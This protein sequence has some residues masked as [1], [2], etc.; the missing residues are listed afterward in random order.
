MSSE[1][2]PTTLV[3]HLQTATQ[4]YPHHVAIR[5][6][7]NGEW[8]E[9][10][11]ADL[12]A[13]TTATTRGLIANGLQPGDRVCV[14]SQTRPEWTIVD[15]AILRAG[16]VVVPVYPTSSP[17]EIRWIVADSGA[18]WIVC[19]NAEMMA[20][21]DAVAGE[22]PDLEHRYLI[23]DDPRAP[24]APTLEGLRTTGT[25]TSDDQLA[26][27][28]A[29][30]EPGSVSTVMYTSGTTG[31]PKGCLLTHQNLTSTI[32]AVAAAD[33]I[34]ASDTVY[35]F[36]PL[37]H[38]FAR[39]VQMTAVQTGATVAYFGGDISNVI[40]ELSEVRPTF[41]PSVPRIFEKIHA[42]ATAGAADAS[43]PKRAVFDWSLTVGR[44]RA[45]A[46]QAGRPITGL[47]ALQVRLADALVFRRVR[48][49]L[50]GE[51][52]A[53]LTGA[54]PIS[55]DVL[56]F[57]HG[58]GIPIVEGFGMTEATAALS[59]TPKHLPR[60]GTVGTAMAGVELRIADDGEICARGANV[61]AGYLNNPEAT[62]ET[63]RDGW[64]HTGDLGRLDDDGYLTITGRKKDI[65]ITAGGKNLSPAN[66][67]NDLR[68]SRWISHAVMHGDRRPY[69]V[70]LVTLDP[71]ELGHLGQA[72]GLDGA[73]D[74]LASHPD[75][76]ALI[77]ADLDRVN[78]GYS[79]ASQIKK[80]VILPNDFSML[81]G[82]LTPTM[83]LRRAE[84]NRKYADVLDDL[85][86]DAMRPS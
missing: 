22:L 66:L 39:M 56:E 2:V 53:C 45:A 62:Q 37:A 58:A 76:R 52:R 34:D 81:G 6:K 5:F 42:T 4:T 14:L 46:L 54:A 68:Q 32:D 65:I 70:A 48:A 64:L 31:R 40:E 55:H 57:F 86:A 9:R 50:G 49:V 41:L 16:G 59:F 13:E 7:R 20:K 63:L 74:D 35:L 44:R 24:L 51:I 82:E 71:D 36:L 85:Y 18:T 17:D 61:F 12:E 79:K 19:E 69:P 43:R 29:A 83:K 78:A 3:A 75:V 47:L 33:L 25:T 23:D 84:I 27:R 80:F 67:E 30:V 15:H 26:E 28:A 60:F 8:H 10:T 38:V 1:S 77:Q 11:Y 72:V 73:A 21:V